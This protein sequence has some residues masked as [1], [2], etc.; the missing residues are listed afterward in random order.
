METGLIFIA[1]RRTKELVSGNVVSGPSEEEPGVL[2]AI[3]RRKFLSVNACDFVFQPV[4]RIVGCVVGAGIGHRVAGLE[5]AS[6]MGIRHCDPLGREWSRNGQM[7]NLTLNVSSTQRQSFSDRAAT[8][9]EV[10]RG[11]LGGWGTIF[12]PTPSRPK[13]MHHST[14]R[15]L[16]R[17]YEIACSNSV[18][19]FAAKMGIP[20]EKA[21]ELG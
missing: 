4:L 14:Y 7:S 16:A 10:I 2:A 17:A 15:R 11:C 9:T 1:T 21:L 5:T 3:A 18:L 19:D 13:W 6:D 8:R 12:Y 20:E